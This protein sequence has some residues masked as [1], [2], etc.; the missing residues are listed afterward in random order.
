MAKDMPDIKGAKANTAVNPRSVC[1]RLEVGEPGSRSM[2]AAHGLQRHQ[3]SQ[4]LAPMLR[5]SCDAEDLGPQAGLGPAAH[6]DN[7]SGAVTSQE[8][9]G[10]GV[11]DERGGVR[12]ESEGEVGERPKVADGGCIDEFDG[13]VPAVRPV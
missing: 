3:C 2:S 6:G 8:P 9:M 11:A 13:D 1:R 5:M 12:A 10:T 4:S 7:L